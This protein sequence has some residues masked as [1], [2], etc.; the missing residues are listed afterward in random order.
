MGIKGTSEMRAL[1]QRIADNLTDLDSERIHDV[2]ID[3]MRRKKAQIP[4]DTGALQRSLT[5]KGDRAHVFEATRDRGGWLIEFGSTL[6]QAIY[7][8]H[9]IPDPDYTRVAGAVLELLFSGVGRG[10]G[11]KV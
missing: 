4:K 10:G 6:P 3:D 8:G 7:Q 9:R 5:R 1:A 2:L 11:R